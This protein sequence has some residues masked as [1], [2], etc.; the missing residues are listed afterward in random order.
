M[1][2]S[3]NPPP[4]PTALV[5]PAGTTAPTRSPAAG[6]PTTGPK[7]IVVVRDAQRPAAR[8]GLDARGRHRGRAGRDRLARRAQR[9]APL[10]RARARPGRAGPVPRG[11]ARH[12]PADRERLLLRLRRS[13]SRSSPT[14]W[15]S[16]RSGCRR[17]SRPG[18]GS[19]AAGSPR[20]TRPR[21]SS[22]TS[23]SS[24]SWSTSRA[25]STPAEVMEVGGGELT[26]YDNLDA[27][28]GERVLGR[29]VPR[30][31]PAHHPAASAAF[32]LMRTRRRVLAGLGEE[33]AAA[34]HLRHRVADPGR[35]QGVPAA[36][37]GGRPARPPQARRGAGPVL[38]SPTRSAPGWRCS[39]PRAAS[40]GGSWRTTRGSGTRRPATRSSTPRTSPRAQLFETSGHLPYYADTHVPADADGGRGLLPQ[41]DELPVAQPDL[42]ARAAA[43]TGSCRC[44]CSSSARSTGT[45]SPAWCT[46]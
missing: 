38:A 18:S 27:K 28:S 30:P 33:P 17:S 32:K 16:S 12:R 13:P 26:I 5:V 4:W 6:L 23:R 29:P 44:G 34:A 1:S 10:D 36:A 40:S 24:W 35:A 19:A 45:R 11:Q 8:P 21:R 37:G 31:A 3:R 25:T 15:P 20:S 46:A 41:A 2:A 22:P 42:P 14:T 9:A 7:A 39:T 43:P